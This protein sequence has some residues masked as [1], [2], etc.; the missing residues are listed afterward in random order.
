MKGRLVISC[1]YLLVTP[2]PFFR[3]SEGGVWVDRLWHRDLARHIEYIEDLTVAAPRQ[4]SSAGS[5]DLVRLDIP[6]DRRVRFLRVPMGGSMA[7]ALLR[8]PVSA[9]VLLGAVRGADLVHSGVAGWPYPL[10][11]FANPFAVLLR[12]RLV[13]VV[14]SSFWRVPDGTKASR[15]ARVRASLT[16]AFARWSVRRADLSIF[17]TTAYRDELVTRE[18]SRTLVTPASWIDADILLDPRSAEAAWRVKTYQPRLLFAGR[19]TEGKG[20]QVLLQAIEILESRATNCWIDVIGDGPLRA[21]CRTMAGETRTVQMRLLESLPY[22]PEFFG[23]LRGYHAVLVPSITDEQPRIIFDAYS[24]AVPVIA[25]DTSGH[26]EL[27]V[28][29]ETG[30][31]VPPGDAEAL[32][33]AMANVLAT[34]EHAQLAGMR[35]LD[36]AAGFTH[37]AMHAARARALAE[38]VD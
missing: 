28:P 27:V 26:R 31:V 19:L 36:V 35:A 21:A 29:G 13:I 22:G 3:D 8:L 18:A 5:E 7:Q 34:P 24:Q 20:V 6:K 25:S 38:L 10:G 4:A 30:W 33:N 11:V 16:E 14:E 1:R 15:K 32:A 2:I 9:L 17:T 23:V 12:R 37:E